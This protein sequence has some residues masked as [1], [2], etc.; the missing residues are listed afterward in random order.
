[1]RDSFFPDPEFNVQISEYPSYFIP[2]DAAPFSVTEG[3]ITLKG[4]VEPDGT[5][6]IQE[7][8]VETPH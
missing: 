2:A 8:I 5:M 7:E 4:F 3:S 6:H 1:M